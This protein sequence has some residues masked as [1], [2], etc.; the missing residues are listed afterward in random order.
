[1]IDEAVA[2]RL[3]DLHA[4]EA[5]TPFPWGWPGGDSRQAI[6]RT[7]VPG[8]CIAVQGDG[9]PATIRADRPPPPQMPTQE[10]EARQLFMWRGFLTFVTLSV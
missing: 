9:A 2:I 6:G 3:M 8:C 10:S 1:M 5:R 7:W 4:R